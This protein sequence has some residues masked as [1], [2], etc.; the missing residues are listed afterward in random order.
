MKKLLRFVR[1]QLYK[2]DPLVTVRIAKKS[3]LH[4]LKQFQ[5]L[6]EHGNIAPVLKS[7]AYGHGLVEVAKVL[8]ETTV[9]FLIVD[10][11]Y[12]AMVLRSENIK[13]PILIIGYTH[14]SNILKSNLPDVA[15]TIM[16]PEQLAE[17]S[18][19]LQK[20]THFHI[21]FDTGM[22]RQGLILAKS[23]TKGACLPAGRQ[24]AISWEHLQ[25]L[26]A[27]NTNILIQGIFSHLADAD[28]KNTKSTEKQCST[29]NK[30]VM[31]FKER[32]GLSQYYHLNATA[33]L[34][35][36]SSKNVPRGTF[37]DIMTNVDRLGLGLYGIDFG[38]VDIDLRPCLSMKTTITSVKEVLSGEY[39][40]YNCTYKADS[41]MLV[42]NIPVGYFEGADRRLS[43]KGFVY[44]PKQE[45]VPRGT[46]CKIL[47]RVSMNITTIDV[48]DLPELQVGAQV[49]VISSEKNALNS[50]SGI[51]STIDT[52][53]YEVIAH[54]P[55][56]LRRICE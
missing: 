22:R 48:T 50:V 14:T 2:Y 8:D 16:T 53:P 41:R 51:A 1:K 56:K 18:Q 47:G 33:G 39:I 55:S 49:V 24:G 46:F 54:I 10:T 17:I 35:L 37:F 52:I 21:K 20:Q 29:W 28:N 34:I 27:V 15:F 38:G 6:S 36:N 42:A 45:N 4:N 32:F 26:I 9:P 7:N 23:S 44:I 13:K 12:E 43:N 30:I 3:L 31:E 11:Y 25:K 40:G 19:K 5:E